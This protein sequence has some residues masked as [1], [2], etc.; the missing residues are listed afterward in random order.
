M[1][2]ELEND[3][4]FG[5]SPKKKYMDIIFNANRNLVEEYLHENIKYM[6]ALELLLEDMMGE[7]KDI[8]QIVR[9]YSFEN[10]NK[11]DDRSM[12]L[13]VDGMGKIL[14]QNE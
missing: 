1:L 13:M 8:V 9:N 6:A 12:D 5:G 14:T 7:D 3:P 11:I 10:Q 4:L 2:E